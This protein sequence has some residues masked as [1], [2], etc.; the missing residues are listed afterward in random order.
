MVQLILHGFCAVTTNG[1]ESVTKVSSN[2]KVYIEADHK[3]HW[4]ANILI[5]K[6][7]GKGHENYIVK[8][9]QENHKNHFYNNCIICCGGKA[10]M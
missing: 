5:L 7:I 10:N 9:A 4:M 8:K 3:Y 1:Q 6:V 2:S